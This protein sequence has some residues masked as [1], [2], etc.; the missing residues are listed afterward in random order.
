MLVIVIAGAVVVTAVLLY[1]RWGSAYSTPEVTRTSLGGNWE[2]ETVRS[3]GGTSGGHRSLYRRT[4]EGRREIAPI[5]FKETYVGDDCVIY[6]T[7]ETCWA[8]CGRRQ[9]IRI[10]EYCDRWE[11]VDG[12]LRILNG[13]GADTTLTVNEIKARARTAPSASSSDRK[14]RERRKPD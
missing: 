14:G 4:T 5:V 13:A 10:V 1:I 2:T 11:I 9:A 3:L 12:T 7:P 8:A 6:A